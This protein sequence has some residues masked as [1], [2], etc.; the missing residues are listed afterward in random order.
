MTS[1]YE[2][3]IRQLMKKLS[4][5]PDPGMVEGLARE[6]LTERPVEMLAELVSGLGRLALE[7]DARIIYSSVVRLSLSGEEDIPQQVREEIYSVLAARGEGSLV[8]YLLP[9]P[10]QRQAADIDM[11]RDPV[12]DEMTLGMRKWKARGRSKD[13]LLRL[14]RD[15]DPTVIRVLLDN[16]LL[17]ED[18][19]VRFAARRPALPDMLMAIS[20]HRKWSLSGRVLE[21]L[22]R[23]PYTPTH[24]AAAFMPLFA[25]HLL[26]RIQDDSTL[27]PLVR[28]AAFDVTRLR[29]G[30]GD[31]EK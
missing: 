4:V 30:T 12:L 23:N 28:E 18:D 10:P 8:R 9:L 22:A 2:I 25:G 27:H 26:R 24:V 15:R 17:T 31:E 20:I 6:L 14:S 11:P 16:P 21:A 3:R 7:Q 1:G 5:V 29:T 13:L 19:V